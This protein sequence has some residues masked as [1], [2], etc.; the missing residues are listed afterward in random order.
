MTVNNKINTWLWADWPAPAHVKA[1]TSLRHYGLSQTPYHSLNLAAHVGD[2]TSNIDQNRSMICD[3]LALKTDPFWLEQTHGGDVISIDDPHIENIAD[4]A[5]TTRA[6]PVCTVMTADCVPV[7]FCDK[8]G[9]KVA[10]IHAGWKG[11]CSGIIE[12]TVKQ[13]ADPGRVLVWIGPCISKQYY[14]V[15][16]D[17]VSACC[18]H[19]SDLRQAFEKTGDKH[20][21]C[22]LSGLVK[23]ILTKFKINS[24]YE[25]GLCTFKRDDLFYSY[26]RDGITG[27][28]ATMIW[29]E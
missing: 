13:Y 24:V 12:N 7:L 11:I 2:D 8:P 17:V 15:G 23:I 9:T 1:G 29:I 14:A 19:F 21:V 18:L 6:G 3:H 4:G 10:A 25:C 27:R 16:E 26:R 20:W 5:I 28:T 22:D